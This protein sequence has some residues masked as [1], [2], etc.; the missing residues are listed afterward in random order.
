MTDRI[1]RRALL[2]RIGAAAAVGGSTGCLGGGGGSTPTRTAETVASREAVTEYVRSS[3]YDGRTVD[4]TGRDRVPV[5]VG[6]RGNGGNLA[7]DPPAIQVDAGTTVVWEWNGQGGAHN[8]VAEDDTFDSGTAEVSS[9]AT[10]EHTFEETG[11]YRYFCT[12]HVR[13]GMVGAVTVV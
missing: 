10:F 12:P 4:L 6:A 3:N 7:Y 2:R 8:V 11:V 9:V 13:L 5:V 1:G